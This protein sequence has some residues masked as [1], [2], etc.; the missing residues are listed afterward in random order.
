MLTQYFSSTS[1]CLPLQ[2]FY[3]TLPTRRENPVDYWLRLNKAADVAEEGLNR[4]G[5]RMENMGG[6]IAK[7]FV[8]HCPD[9]ELASVFK[10]KQIH[11]WTTKEIQER[12]D[13]YQREQVS[14]TKVHVPETHV[15][16]LGCHET[17][18]ESRNTSIMEA[19]CAN[20]PSPPVLS[21]LGVSS[22]SPS[23][24]LP[25]DQQHSLS[26][27]SQCRQSCAP[28]MPQ[29]QRQT[30]PPLPQSQRLSPSFAPRDQLLLGQQSG[31]DAMLGEMMS[32]L[33]E[34]LSNVQ[35]GQARPAVRRG[36]RQFRG[37]PHVHATSCQVCNDK[38]HTTESHCRSDRL[39]FTC[40]KPG[41]ASRSCPGQFPA[42]SNLQGN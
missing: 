20:V 29:H 38:G 30:L 42:H 39:C 7:M 27:V 11:E 6:E 35:A 41:H 40:F 21:L 16:T 10:Y 1:S 13:E 9:L 19:S 26:P 12:V 23:S 4:Q 34:L 17:H 14:S 18:T 32:M 28:P 2:D 33:R 3:S 5:R 8:K 24:T 22:L 31:N 37:Q 25:Q 15:A 36:G